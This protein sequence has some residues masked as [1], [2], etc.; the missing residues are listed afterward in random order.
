MII[1]Y[2]SHDIPIGYHSTTIV[3]MND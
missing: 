1:K 3:H 2:G